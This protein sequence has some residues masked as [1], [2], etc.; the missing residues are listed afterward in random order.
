M[1]M[2][3]VPGYR[4]AKLLPS[5]MVT[6]MLHNCF[7]TSTLRIRFS[8]RL[9]VNAILLRKSSC[10]NRYRRDD[11]LVGMF[12]HTE[13][14]GGIAFI[15]MQCGGSLF[16]ILVACQCPCHKIGISRIG[17][18]KRVR[19]TPFDV[20]IGICLS[21][22]F[23][24]WPSYRYNSMSSAMVWSKLAVLPSYVKSR[25]NEP[26]HNLCEDLHGYIR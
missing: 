6:E 22:I 26:R 12:A 7:W 23:F 5:S 3:S 10:M 18:L 4:V 16:D 20:F 1:A 25:F 11:S 17:Q 19:L 8:C 21:S 13:P 24:P 9:W 14:G 15:V 2:L